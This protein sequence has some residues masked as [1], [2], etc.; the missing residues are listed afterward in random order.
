MLDEDGRIVS[1]EDNL[2]LAGEAS[3]GEATKATKQDVAN[4][5]KKGGGGRGGK[6]KKAMKNEGVTTQ[7]S[8]YMYMYSFV[9]FTALYDYH[10]PFNYFNVFQ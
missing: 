1:E 8:C 7:V 2:R 10:S 6:R 4:K 5:N 9:M 3:T